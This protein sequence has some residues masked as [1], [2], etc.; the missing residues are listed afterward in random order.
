MLAR[1][2]GW[3]DNL[4]ALEERPRVVGECDLYLSSSTHPIWSDAQV[5]APLGHSA[6]DNYGE[7]VYPIRNESRAHLVEQH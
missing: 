5:R 4:V 1:L 2:A 3:D 6:Y 7:M